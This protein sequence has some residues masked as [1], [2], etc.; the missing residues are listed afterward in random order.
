M[1]RSILLLAL[2]PLLGAAGCQKETSNSWSESQWSIHE[3][4]VNIHAY[5]ADSF[6]A[7]KAIVQGTD[8]PDKF[9]YGLFVCEN[10]ETDIAHKKNS[11]NLKS[12]YAAGLEGEAGTWSFQYVENYN[13]GVLSAN[14]YDHI[15]ITAKEKEQRNITADLY[16]YAPHIQGTF[17]PTAIPVSIASNIEDQADLMYAIENTDPDQNKNLDP[18]S[19]DGDLEANFTFKHALAL[20]AFEF[21]IKN[22][23]TYSNSYY[24]Q[25]IR[26]DK[27]SS[28]TSAELYGS[29]TFNAID[30]SF[31]AKEDDKK[32]NLEINF[33]QK[34][35]HTSQESDLTAYV[36][37]VPTQ[38]EDDELIVNFIF[39]SAP[40]GMEVKPFV[41]KKNY[42]KHNDGDTYGFQG[43]YKYTFRLTLDNYLFLDGFTVGTWEEGEP[44]QD[45]EI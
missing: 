12:S 25:A 8:I 29:A 44:L 43:G 34:F 5:L 21:K 35:S 17:N 30:G 2:L 11:W 26:I 41:L 6:G 27:A 38:I 45:I 14:A 20:L 28:Q 9:S 40:N 13:S 32:D 39:N 37:L 23:G 1:K 33:N 7:T 3:M 19:G 15:T 36:A 16:A 10:G 22:Y 31:N 4:P 18:L 24:L 42:V